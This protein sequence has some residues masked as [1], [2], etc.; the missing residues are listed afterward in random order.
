M[1]VSND[2]W[3]NI[4]ATVN[5][6]LDTIFRGV[7]V[8]NYEGLDILANLILNPN[9]LESFFS[10]PDDWISTVMVYPFNI[11]LG[12][13]GTS[14]GKLQLGLYDTKI[15]CYD[16]LIVSE[17]YEMG[18]LL[19]EPHFNNF[20]DYDG[21][22]K[23]EV[24]LPFLGTVDISLN[25]VIGKYLKFR[26]GVDYISGQGIWYICVGDTP[27]NA[28]SVFVDL[29]EGANDRIL[30]TH[31]CQIGMQLPIGTT[32]TASVYRNL[33]MGAVKGVST[34]LSSYAIS[35]LGASGGTA[36]TKE[37]RTAR[38]EKTGRQITKATKTTETKYN[39]SNYQLGKS[40]TGV[41][42]YATDSLN[43]MH[44]SASTDRSNNP[45]TMINTCKSIKV[46]RYYPKLITT[47]ENYGKLYGYPLGQTKVLSTLSGY[48]EISNIHIE[49]EGFKS[50]TQKEILML[51]EALSDGIIL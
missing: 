37:V 47:D 42:D 41:F 28:T 23:M 33:I 45:T 21:Y 3:I 48:T 51:K 6:K 49:G 2:K 31:T 44:I 12:R 14:Q 18:E 9:P 38:N 39:S 34:A 35:S 10:K 36:T 50:A 13:N 15:D 22:S 30:S 11:P 16:L 17:M 32:N 27:T 29:L 24:W 7:R 20:A 46:I 26:L 5:G 25:D 4:S 43:N 40:I 19:I 1:G 8:L